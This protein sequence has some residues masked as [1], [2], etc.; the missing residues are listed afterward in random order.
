[1]SG[2][3]P[4]PGGSVCVTSELARPQP[5]QAL[6]LGLALTCLARLACA[7]LNIANPAT[8]GQKLI[9]IDDDKKL[10]AASLASAAVAS[11]AAAGLRA[12]STAVAGWG[13]LRAVS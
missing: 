11:P 13:G 2:L 10:C 1:M 12:H 8:G 9:E 3:P 5:C 6:A 7:Q 4:W